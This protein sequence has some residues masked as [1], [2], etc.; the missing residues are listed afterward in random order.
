MVP[1]VLT[2]FLTLLSVLALVF[3]Y[4]LRIGAERNE[5]GRRI[6]ALA[7]RIARLESRGGEFVPRAEPTP[8]RASPRQATRRVDG[9]EPRVMA[10]PTLIAIP[11]LA[12]TGGWVPAP[13]TTTDLGRRFGSI[14]ELAADGAS[15]EAIARETGQP[16][17][18]VE[19][20]LGLK[21]KLDASTSTSGGPRLP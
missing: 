12:A 1:S 14:W 3:A 7:E 11:D 9:S 13:S 15:A 2:A 18:Q 8:T 17:G 16:V 4:R 21:R 6:G 10:G 5:T 19:L 20:I